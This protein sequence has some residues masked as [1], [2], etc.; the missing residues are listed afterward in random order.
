[1]FISL[2]T[3]RNIFHWI[4]LPWEEL[5]KDFR[6]LRDKVS[7]FLKYS[8]SRILGSLP[9][10]NKTFLLKKMRVLTLRKSHDINCA[11]YTDLFCLIPDLK[12]V[13]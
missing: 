11:V 1:M 2:W 4:K 13:W 6:Q 7:V 5:C 8:G 10:Y 12:S 3:Y 9:K